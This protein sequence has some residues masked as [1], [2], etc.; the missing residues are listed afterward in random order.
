MKIARIWLFRRF[1]RENS[2]IRTVH[3]L[4]ILTN[5]TLIGQ[6]VPVILTLGLQAIV[7]KIFS[8]SQ[9]VELHCPCTFCSLLWVS[10]SC[11]PLTDHNNQQD[12]TTQQVGK[13]QRTMTLNMMGDW[14]LLLIDSN[15]PRNY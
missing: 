1:F 10:R 2:V 13:L 5:P 15:M 3:D 6:G 8:A 7:N 14:R 9:H 4:H 11:Y 12:N